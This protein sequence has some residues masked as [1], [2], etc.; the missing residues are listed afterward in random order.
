NVILSEP[1]DLNP[2]RRAGGQAASR[3]VA[4]C[5]GGNTI[6]VARAIAHGSPLQRCGLDRAPESD[7]L[8]ESCSAGAR[9]RT[10]SVP[11]SAG[12]APPAPVTPVRCPARTSRRL[13]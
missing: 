13:G 12:P 2:S 4:P 11:S 9:S 10:L 3:Q 1:K 6:R 7:P 5:T 8:F